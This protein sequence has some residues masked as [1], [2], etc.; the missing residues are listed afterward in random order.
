MKPPQ[1]VLCYVLRHIALSDIGHQAELAK[2][3][4]T[5]VPAQHASLIT[6]GLSLDQMNPVQ[7]LLSKFHLQRGNEVHW[8]KERQILLDSLLTDTPVRFLDRSSRPE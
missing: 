6:V 4:L 7:F 3:P 5:E 1:C 8:G 2:L